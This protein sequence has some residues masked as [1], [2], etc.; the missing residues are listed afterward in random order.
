M[1]LRSRLLIFLMTTLKVALS[2]VAVFFVLNILIYGGYAIYETKLRKFS[3]PISEYYQLDVTK[4][5]PGMTPEQVDQLIS[6]GSQFVQYEPFVEFRERPRTGR[7]VNVF[8]PGFRRSIDQ[9]TWPPRHDA[10]IIFVFGGSTTFGYGVGDDDTVVSLLHIT[11]QQNAKFANAQIY[12]FGRGFYWSTQEAV[13]FMRLLSSHH[14]PD[15]AIFIDGLNEF[16]YQENTPIFAAEMK[17]LFELEIAKQ[18]GRVLDLVAVGGAYL[19]ASLPVV[20]LARDLRAYL[21]GSGPYESRPRLLQHNPAGTKN[22]IRTYLFNKDLITDMGRSFDVKTL[23]V[24][25]PIPTYEYPVELNAAFEAAHGYGPHSQS[26]YGY[27]E[28]RRMLGVVGNRENLVWCADILRS[29]TE[30]VYVDLVHYNR[31]GAELLA[32]CIAEAVF[33]MPERAV[34]ASPAANR[35]P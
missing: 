7:Y 21:G 29:E 16:Y 33:A 31:R 13:L 19:Y 2:F 27:P 1:P 28:M 17:Q 35:S 4:Y 6:E 3:N 34:G 9:A 24:W 25:Q 5:Y 26:Y 23:F 20:R 18:R 12:N 11:L 14:N 10:P 8:E 22:S 32:G 15:I 30:P